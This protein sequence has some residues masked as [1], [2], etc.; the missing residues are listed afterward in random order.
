[1]PTLIFFS[2]PLQFL[3]EKMKIDRSENVHCSNHQGPLITLKVY[4][5]W[6]GFFPFTNFSDLGLLTEI[7]SGMS[8]NFLGRTYW[9]NK[10]IYQ[11]SWQTFKENNSPKNAKT[12]YCYQGF[13]APKFLKGYKQTRSRKEHFKFCCRPSEGKILQFTAFSSQKLILR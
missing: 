12:L 8:R 10:I 4:F 3:S 2:Q 7:I 6:V 11:F 9:H 5:S 13:L 1:M